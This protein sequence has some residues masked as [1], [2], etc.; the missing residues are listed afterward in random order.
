[1]H[2]RLG[3]AVPGDC[4][5]EDLDHHV[6]ALGVVDPVADHVARVIVD[7]DQAEGRRAMDVPLNVIG[8]P[9]MIRTNSL[10]ALVVLLA[11]DLR[12]PVARIL[13]HVSHRVHRHLDALASQLVSDLARP[14]PG[15]IVPL[16][17][18]L[19]I[20]LRL[21]VLRIGP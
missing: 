16:P 1:M 11:L 12:R 21:D 9:D 20:T 3:L 7:E 6:G 17:E 4:L 19:A 13:H 15:M 8:M 2:H 18:D 10:V 14:E 5:L